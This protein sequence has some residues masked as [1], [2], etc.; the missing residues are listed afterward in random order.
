MLMRILAK[1]L[2]SILRYKNVMCS[3]G[4]EWLVQKYK[5][6]K[7]S[8][9]FYT[10]CLCTTIL[11]SYIMEGGQEWFFVSFLKMTRIIG[12]N[13]L[14]LFLKG[15]FVFRIRNSK[16]VLFK[17]VPLFFFL[18]FFSFLGSLNDDRDAIRKQEFN[19][20]L[21]IVKEIKSS[22]GYFLQNKIWFENYA[23][24]GI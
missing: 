8:H 4:C 23:F 14:S 3:N 9:V 13:F 15:R 11:V 12:S 6:I 19:F 17:N 18:D 5:S 21:P 22:L 2:G 20:F 1:R 7:L 16:E 24:W 10:V